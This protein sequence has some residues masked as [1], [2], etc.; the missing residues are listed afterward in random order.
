[1]IGFMYGKTK[2]QGTEAIVTKTKIGF[3]LEL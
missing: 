3:L 2:K 1:M